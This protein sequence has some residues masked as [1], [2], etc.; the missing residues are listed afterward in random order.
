MR[1]VGLPAGGLSEIVMSG[2]NQP[3][4]QADSETE[5]GFTFAN[6]RLEPDGTLLRGDDPIHLT[7]KEL[8]ALRVLL[9]N[10]NR[11][12]TPAH[13][14]E[15]LWPNIHVTAD[16]V[17]RCISSLRSRLGPEVK[18]HTLY[19]R[20]YR[21]DSPVHRHSTAPQDTLPRLAILPFQLGLCVPEHL[22]AA[23]AEDAA[24]QLG[25]FQPAIVHVLAWDSLFTLAGQG[26]T[27]QEIGRKVGADLVLA[28]ALHTSA[29]F[30]R[31][32][33]EMIRV[34][35]GTQLWTEDLLAPRERP[36]V[37]EQRLLDRLAY[38]LGGQIPISIVA[39]ARGAVDEEAV[40]SAFG[41]F[42][43]GRYE[44]RSRD[45]H[46][47]S[48]AMD[49]LRKAA[50]LDPSTFAAREQLARVST[51]QCLYGYVSPV[52][53][54]EQI[55][56]EADA[57]PEI[58]YTSTAIFPALGWIMF[59][60]E[61]QLAFASRML[62][63][64]SAHGSSSWSTRLRIL[65]TLSRNRFDEARTMLD[66]ALREDPFAPS[67]HV[68]LAWTLH[69]DGRPQGSLDQANRCL[70]LFP[71]DERAELC[72]ALILAYNNDPQ[73]A[74]ALAHDVGQRQPLLDVAAAIEAYALARADRVADATVILER[75]QWLGRERYVLRA[76]TA[77]AY[78]ELG[79][80]DGAIAELQAAEQ[81]RCPWFFQT[82]ADPRLKS[83]RGNPQFDRMRN[84]L[85]SME[86]G[87][88]TGSLTLV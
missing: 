53:A 31:L 43:W 15:T 68:L 51:G 17:P 16:S 84:Q 70:A 54:A 66:Q 63:G 88:V 42:L 29:L 20:G 67:L 25:D 87:A 49:L 33:A 74:A 82:L 57:I 21:L 39:G 72:A 46:R 38:R 80:V 5:L 11:I 47:M 78:A 58:E 12:V 61:H 36:A 62:N 45:P 50:D 76:F 28:G 7:P 60:V 32:R 18:I 73:R 55:R 8:A 26:L 6:L 86:S 1:Q 52:D 44:S 64:A 4:L 83:L 81:A 27:A 77:A 30:L 71:G 40:A 10:P 69:L 48:D 56:R 3:L 34:S 41:A 75:L 13:L 59:H 2:M 22:G 35:D 65:L 85:E 79:D 37:L 24:T 14:K 19:K 23:I 9:A